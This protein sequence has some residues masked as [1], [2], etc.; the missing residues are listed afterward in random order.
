MITAM[1]LPSF[2]CMYDISVLLNYMRYI[3]SHT[4]GPADLLSPPQ[5]LHFKMSAVFI[6]CFPKCPELITAHNSAPG[7][8]LY[9]FLP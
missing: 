7:V 6:S 3:I 4:I 5:T 2:Y 8:L 9:W 1:N